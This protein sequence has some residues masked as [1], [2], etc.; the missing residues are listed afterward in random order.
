MY[1]ITAVLLYYFSTILLHTVHT[2][3]KIVLPICMDMK[4]F[5]KLGGQKIIN[6]KAEIGILN[7]MYT[8]QAAWLVLMY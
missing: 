1:Y 2:S 8:N 4:K 6:L 5:Q 7:S 3:H